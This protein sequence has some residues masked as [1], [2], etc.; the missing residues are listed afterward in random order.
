MCIRDRKKD[1]HY[2]F[3]L[4][5]MAQYQHPIHLHGMTFKVLGSDRRK[6]IPYLSLIHI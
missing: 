4:R 3:V 5:N 2:I 6:I 1:G